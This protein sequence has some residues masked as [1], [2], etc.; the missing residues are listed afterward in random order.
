M[1]NWLDKYQDGGKIFNANSNSEHYSLSEFEYKTPKEFLKNYISSDKY[2]KRLES[3]GYED[4]T[5][6]QTTRKNN[7]EN[8]KVKKHDELNAQYFPTEKTI[9]IHPYIHMKPGIDNSYN[10]VKTHELTHASLD[11]DNKPLKYDYPGDKTESR[12]RLNEYDHNQLRD[13]LLASKKDNMSLLFDGYHSWASDENK[14]DLNA[15]RYSLYNNRLFD[16]SKEKKFTQED[17]ENVRK[18]NEYNLY[19]PDNQAKQDKKTQQIGKRLMENYSDEDLIWLMNNIAENDSKK[20][21]TIGLAKHGKVIEDNRGQWAHPGQ[22]TKINSNDITMQGVNYPVL[23]ISNTGDQKLM[24]PGQDYKFQGENVT[25]YPIV[26]NEGWLE[27]Y[28]K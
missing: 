4:P 8:V 3:S 12:T 14:A 22:I 20:S 9:Y 18:F 1:K 24:M 5:K 25:E 28:N 26:K 10:S 16:D 2:L 19:D 17:L 11:K 13:R 7:V 6:E 15:F 27:K 23:G 21:N